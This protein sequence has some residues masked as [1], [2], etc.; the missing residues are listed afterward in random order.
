MV[1]ADSKSLNEFAN[2]MSGC[3]MTLSQLGYT[4][5]INNIETMKCTANRLPHYLRV[6]WTDK[7]N[8][9]ID[10]TGKEVK[11]KDLF[12]RSTSM[13]K[14]RKLVTITNSARS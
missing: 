11:F 4:D 3:D 8:D 7:A 1:K 5:D 10:R 2:E 9:I 13:V 6:K 14:L 12:C